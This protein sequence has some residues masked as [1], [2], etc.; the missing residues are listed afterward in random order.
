MDF[1]LPCV[2]Q[3]NL[4]FKVPRDFDLKARICSAHVVQTVLSLLCSYCQGSSKFNLTLKKQH[5]SFP[6]HV[7]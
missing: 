7:L 4:G 1:F 2:S 5:P 6:G 3:E